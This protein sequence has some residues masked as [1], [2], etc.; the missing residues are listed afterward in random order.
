MAVEA[1]EHQVQFGDSQGSATPRV[2]GIFHDCSGKVCLAQ[3]A[4]E[5]QP[6]IDFDLILDVNSNEAAV[7]ILQQRR[8]R[9]AS[10]AVN[11]MEELIVLLSETVEARARVIGPLDPRHGPL[12]SFI[13]RSAILRRGAWEIVETTYVVG[14]V[15][16]EERR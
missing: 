1:A 7:W 6:G 14:A 2:R 11:Y 8:D 12:A 13:F 3:P 15:V 5:R 9:S 10:I 16:M 4:V